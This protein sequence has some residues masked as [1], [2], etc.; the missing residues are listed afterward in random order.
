MDKRLFDHLSAKMPEFNPTVCNGVAMTYIQMAER[1]IDRIFRCAEQGFPPGLKYLGL[2]RCTPIEEY[3]HTTKTRNNQRTYEISRNDLYLVKCKFSFQEHPG[4]RE[5][6][7]VR[8]LQLPFLTPGALLTLRGSTFA[9][10][11]VLADKAIS[12]GQNSIFIPLSMA[13]FKFE[14]VTHHFVR[15]GQGESVYVVWSHIHNRNK[16]RQKT[17]EAKRSV[18]GNTTMMHYLF[19]KVGVTRAFA[20][21]GDADVVVGGPEEV[22]ED[23]FPPTKWTICRST[24]IKPRPL[25]DRNYIGSNIRLAIPRDQYN[26]V[27]ASMI[28]GFFYV[29]DHF[30][31]RIYP[32]EINETRLWKALLGRLIFPSG[33]SE[34]KYIE[35]INSH[36]VSLDG[37][38]DDMAKDDLRS[39]DVHCEDIYDLFVHVICT[40][41]SRITQAPSDVSSMYGKRLTVLR[42]LLFNVVEAIFN[43]MFKVRNPKKELKLND[44]ESQ[45]NWYLKHDR[46][47]KA[48]NGHG[49]V[50]IISS[51]GDNKIFKITSNLVLQTDSSGARG[52]SKGKMSISDPSRWLHASIAEVG[53]YGNLPKSAPDG[54]GRIN[55]CVKIDHSGLIE[56]SEKHRALIDG[57][58]ELIKR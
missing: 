1:Y 22:N 46:I 23:T 45:M 52:S 49:E 19:C 50:S 57:V 28:G 11:P 42:Y 20:E 2:T 12:V 55:P 40:F 26:H 5:E 18:N 32:D 21:Y 14:K 43:F 47:M 44:I 56:R 39:D 17:P 24:Q 4:A 41:S 33:I 48:N 6:I 35:D 51:P 16:Q 58:Q 9:V 15:D 25:K 31:H 27:T 8:H 3:R 29:V 38:L 10:S 37:Y 36:L 34:G 53:S 7:I 30:P 13:K 54:R